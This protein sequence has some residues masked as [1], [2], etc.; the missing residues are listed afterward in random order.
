MEDTIN[1]A[2]IGLERYVN[3]SEERWLW[4]RNTGIKREMESLIMA[5][6]EQAIRTN[7][8]KAKIVKT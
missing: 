7:V 8:I 3:N 5:A 1:F 4:L 2:V 6:Q